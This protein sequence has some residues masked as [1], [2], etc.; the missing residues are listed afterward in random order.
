MRSHGEVDSDRR[1]GRVRLRKPTLETAMQVKADRPEA[2]D[3]V[4]HV[5]A[6]DRPHQ[7][8]VGGLHRAGGWKQSNLCGS[9]I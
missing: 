1:S 2:P 9:G 5:E 7:F 8:W 4:H 6:I 3:R